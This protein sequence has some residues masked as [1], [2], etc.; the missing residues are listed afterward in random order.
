MSTQA[1]LT[2]P[3]PRVGEGAFSLYTGAVVAVAMLFGGGARQGL[4]PEAIA[5]LAALPLAAIALFRLSPSRLTSS[6]RWSLVILAAIVALPALQLVPLPPS[7]WRALPGRAEIAATYEV[8]GMA[9]PWLPVS[10]DPPATWFALLSMIPAVAVFLAMESLEPGVR[11]GLVVIVL[12]AAFANVVLGLMQTVDG[13]ESALRFYAITNNERA[14]GFFAN[15]NHFAALLYAAI[16]F[17]AAWAIGLA[18]ERRRAIGL[19]M[20]LLLVLALIVGLALARSRAGIALMLLGGLGCVLLAWRHDRGQSRRL[21]L[22]ALGANLVALLVAFQIGFVAIVQR[23]EQSDVIEDIRWP[24]ASVTA[25]AAVAN[26]P[27]GTGFGTFSPVYERYAPRTLASDRY[28]NHAHDDWLELGL[29]GGAPAVLLALGFLAWFAAAAAAAWR[30]PA[31]ATLDTAL[32]RAASIGIVLILLHSVLDY[33]LRTV[34][35]MVLFAMS[36]S[37]LVSRIGEG[38]GLQDDAG[39]R[40]GPR[41]PSE[42]EQYSRGRAQVSPGQS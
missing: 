3:M 5:E 27:F 24:V 15:A 18:R 4:W 37:L 26:M 25:R 12:V 23:A 35:I 11:R 30:R 32:A 17:A 40:A 20:L 33:P 38:E 1:S 8:A 22:V 9:L 42:A 14:V 34:A 16:P 31:H 6:G 2:V 7:F 10:L 39:L 21:L 13:S 19:S 28:V 29:T 41:S 36:C